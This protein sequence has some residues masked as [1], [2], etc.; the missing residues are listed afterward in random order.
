MEQSGTEPRIGKLSARPLT[1]P[2]K[3]W[4][5]L[6]LVSLLLAVGIWLAVRADMS[7]QR[8]LMVQCESHMITY[9]AMVAQYF[10]KNP[11][12]V[13][14]SG[15]AES[16]IRTI[17]EELGSKGFGDLHGVS[18]ADAWHRNHGIGYIFVGGGL[19]REEIEKGALILFCG[20]EYHQ[21]YKSQKHQCNCLFYYMVAVGMSND[22]MVKVLEKEIQRGQDGTVNY[23]KNAL[24]IMKA[25]LEKR[26]RSR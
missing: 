20:A 25:E 13:L 4:I 10:E 1:K 11:E 22:D 24:E 17:I 12:G 7:Q 21:R 16:V 15:D 9:G 5:V 6:A 3:I 23:S 26:K 2:K 19:T 8:A 18:C 14:P